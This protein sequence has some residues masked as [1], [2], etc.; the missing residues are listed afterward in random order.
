MCISA[1]ASVA[2]GAVLLPAGAYCVQAALRKNR[3]YL[4]LSV[5]PIFFS[6]QQFCEGAVWL[7]LGQN[8]GALSERAS[9]GFLFFALAFWPFWI[10]LSVLLLESQPSRKWLIGFI[11]I[12]SLAWGLVLYYPIAADPQRWLTIQVVHHSVQYNYFALPVYQ[13]VSPS[14]VRF[15]YLATIA[16]P[17]V[18]WSERQGLTF[19]LLLAASAMVSHF[20]FAHAFVSVWCFFAAV[21]ALYLCLVFYRL[22]AASVAKMG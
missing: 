17:L 22:P 16:L 13:V 2:V 6:A 4:V 19:G 20:I 11:T 1:E 7:G 14:W 12:L 9:L 10:P 5:I 21:L 18:V 3:S 8:D 15:F